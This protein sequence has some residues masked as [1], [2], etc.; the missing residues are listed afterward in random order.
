[1]DSLGFPMDTSLWGASTEGCAK[2]TENCAGVYETG[3]YI[4]DQTCS[5][6]LV[7]VCIKDPRGKLS[8]PN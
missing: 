4:A 6:Q 7:A 5:K 3:F 8:G 1:M 2:T